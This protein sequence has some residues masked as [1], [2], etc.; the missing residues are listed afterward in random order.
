MLD[1]IR[2]PKKRWGALLNLQSDTRLAALENELSA[3]AQLPPRREQE[4]QENAARRLLAP[5][6]RREANRVHRRS[7]RSVEPADV[8]A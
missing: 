4:R 3:P 7:G 1:T 2:R 5:R 6:P 8:L